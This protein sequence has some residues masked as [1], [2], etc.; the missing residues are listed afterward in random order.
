MNKQ[1]YKKAAAL[2]H[3]DFQ[4]PVQAIQHHVELAMAFL[5]M[6]GT[7]PDRIMHILNMALVEILSPKALVPEV[8]AVPEKPLVIDLFSN[9][10]EPSSI[11]EE[12]VIAEEHIS[13]VKLS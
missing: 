9:V 5:F 12:N 3:G 6:D 13:T 2:E 4:S 11:P 7:E 8:I 1:S 10:P